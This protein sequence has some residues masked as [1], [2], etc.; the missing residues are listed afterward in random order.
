[1]DYV[2]GKVK[3]NRKEPFK[4]ILSNK[5][6]FAGIPYRP[7]ALVKFQSDHNLDE[8]SWFKIEGFSKK[9]F[10]PSWLEKKFDSKNFNDLLKDEF[11]SL[12]C[13]ISV[14]DEN[15]YF[16]KMTPSLYLRKKVI[17][18]GEVAH[19]ENNCNRLVIKEIPDAVYYFAKDVLVFK[20][21]AAVSSIFDGIDQIYR[22]ATEKETLEFLTQSFV[23]LGKEFSAEKAS[24]PNRKRIALALDTLDK[25][26]PQ[27]KIDMLDYVDEYCKGKLNY[28]RELGVF[29]VSSDED[30][31]LLLY[32]VEQRFYTTPFGQEKRLANSVQRV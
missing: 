32:G 3:K 13:I 21:I 8:D 6:V 18:F 2:V 29:E 27:H 12:S 4:K 1:M 7:G 14:Q 16:Q 11:S 10:F 5:S 28:D 22:E 23:S 31:K 25:M 17:V 26:S 9:P 19:L 30:L 20:N 15:L 24:K